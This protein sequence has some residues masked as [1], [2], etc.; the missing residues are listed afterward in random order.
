MVEF[1]FYTGIAGILIYGLINVIRAWR[2][3]SFDEDDL[4]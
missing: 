1:F 4:I 2:D 3:E